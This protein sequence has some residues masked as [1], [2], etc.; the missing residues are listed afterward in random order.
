MVTDAVSKIA[1]TAKTVQ[2]VLS[3]SCFGSD[4]YLLNLDLPVV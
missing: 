1:G 2:H 3:N 4:L